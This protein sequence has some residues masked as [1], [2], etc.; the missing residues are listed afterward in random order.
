MSLLKPLVLAVVTTLAA[1]HPIAASALDFNGY[2]RAGTGASNS[3]GGGQSCFKLA[4]AMSKYRLGNECEAYGEAMFG[5]ELYQ[6]ADGTRLTGHLMASLFVPTGLENL[7][8][9]RNTQ[10]L[11]QAYLALNELKWL[12]GSTLWFGNRFYKR[13]DVHLN[14]FFYWNP[15]GIGAGIENYALGQLKLSYAVFRKDSV[16]QQDVAPRHDLQL[17][18]LTLNPG[19]ELQLGLSY[20]GKTDNAPDRHTGASFSI[21]HVQSGIFGGWNKLAVQYGQGP[22]IGLGS[23]GDLTN[24]KEVT[25]F[26]IVEQLYFK[27]APSLDGQ[28]TTTWQ[29]DK[30]P[31]ANQDWY[32]LGWS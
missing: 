11:P 12:G 24:G 18:G 32:S 14:D 21:Q 25:R 3:A 30:A 4:G 22:G 28:V 1:I 27:I 6:S 10:R 29:H 13:E 17:R 23:T 9:G 15:S 7:F 5:Q 2:V 16:Y 19:G 20:I 8:D 26:R 31:G